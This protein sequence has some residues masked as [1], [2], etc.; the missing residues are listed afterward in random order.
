MPIGCFILRQ[1]VIGT[2]GGQGHD[3]VK[4][5]GGAALDLTDHP[6]GSEN[7]K[8]TTRAIVGGVLGALIA[9]AAALGL[10][11]YVRRRRHKAQEAVGCRPPTSDRSGADAPE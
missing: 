10:V 5:C 7:A 9:F 11:A 6:S 4:V 8:S 3:I 1:P 2:L